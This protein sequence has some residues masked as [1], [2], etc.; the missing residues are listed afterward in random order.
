MAE[1]DPGEAAM[2]LAAGLDQWRGPPLD[3]FA[4]ETFAQVPIAK[5]EEL[6]LSAIE[7]KIDADLA[8]GR[9]PDLL[10]DLQTL[11]AEHPLQERLRA[12]YMLALY[13]SG[14]Q[15]EALEAYRE[16]RRMFT[17]ELGIDPAPALQRLERTILAQDPA[18]EWP[19]LPS[20][21]GSR[22]EPGTDGGAGTNA[23]QTFLI[24]D[25]RGYSTYTQEYGD[26]A[27][28]RLAAR[29]AELTRKGVEARAGI[30]IELRGDEAG[31]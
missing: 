10:G 14:R 26:E 15:A 16:A 4:Y 6:R 17:D 11:V 25:I 30:V 13:R 2:L 20:A 8:L 3:E 22:T 9:H 5:L 7:D 29:F 27:A 28:A 12:Q 19:G 24:A 1:G 23:I 31:P 18:L 21:V